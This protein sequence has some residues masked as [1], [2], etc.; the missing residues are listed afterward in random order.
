MYQNQPERKNVKHWLPHLN[1]MA[2]HRALDPPFAKGQSQDAV[3]K[4]SS[5]ALF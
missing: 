3:W 4:H 2:S 1:Q 5:Q